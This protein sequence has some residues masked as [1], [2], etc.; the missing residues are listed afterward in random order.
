MQIKKKNADTINYGIK[1]RFYPTEEQKKVLNQMFSARRIFWNLA[2][3][4]YNRIYEKNKQIK[5][6][7]KTSAEKK[8][9]IENSLHKGS[10]PNTDLYGVQTIVKEYL[11]NDEKDFS[12]LETQNFAIFESSIKDLDQSWEAFYKNLKS[13]LKVGKPSRKK[14]TTTQTVKLRN[15]SSFTDGRKL[16]DWKRGLI[17]TP[18]FKKLGWCK[19][20]L[21][22]KFKGKVK[23]TTFSLTNNG[24]YYI[25]LTIEEQGQYPTPQITPNEENTIGIDFGVKTF[26]T[27]AKPNDETSITKLNPSVRDEILKLEKKIK[28]LQRKLGKCLVRLTHEEEVQAEMTVNEL[29]K[30]FNENRNVTKGKKKE[31]SNGYKEYQRKIAKL[32]KRISEIK[33]KYIENFAND[34]VANNDVNL[35]CV[36]D[37]NIRD[38]MIRDK[39]RN[40]EGKKL[41]KSQRFRHKIAK[42]LNEYAIS[43]CI[44]Q[45]E[46]DCKK[47]GKHFVKIGKYQPSTKTCQCGYVNDNIDLGVRK[48]TCPNC[49]RIN[50]RDGNAAMNIAKWGLEKFQNT[51]KG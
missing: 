28:K 9:L 35:V 46:Y 31:Y 34:I 6:E 23:Y 5:E 19:C 41:T 22:R 11:E 24:E 40:A 39:T 32:H 12:W 49:G 17:K 13:N 50:D 38:M 10:F 25:S 3:E 37:L 20:V 7:N 18:G 14:R 33:K 15:G 4:K 45:I 27:I 30:K 48:W 21:H 2:L 43:T 47:S 8:P 26:A 36:E 16:I 1:Y 44:N 42:K 51:N 29:T